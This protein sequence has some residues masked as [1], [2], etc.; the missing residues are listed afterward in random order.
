MTTTSGK[1][2]RQTHDRIAIVMPTWVGDSCMATPT[3]RALRQTY[4]SAEITMISRPV[5][6]ELIAGG[7]GE[8]A[9]WVDDFI[10]V[11]KRGHDD[12][13]SRL[14]LTKVC[15]ARKFDLAVLLTNSFWSAAVMRMAGV[16][17]IVGYNRDARS[18]LLTD[19]L[20]V[21][22]EAGKRKPISAVDYYLTLAQYLDADD[23]S[24]IEPSPTME[25]H[26][27]PAEATLASQLWTAIGLS[28]SHPTLVINSNAATDPRRLWPEER[29]AELAKRTA[30]ELDWQ[31][32]LHCGPTERESSARIAAEVADRRV[33]SMGVWKDLPIGLS[34]AVMQQADLV[35]STDSGPRHIA[36]ALNRQVIA[37]L[38]PIDPAWTQT[39]NQPEI[40]LRGS[41]TNK[42]PVMADISVDEVFEAIRSAVSVRHQFQDRSAA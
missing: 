11:S 20:S 6:K 22:M 36:V 31:V 42:E 5:I 26:V 3:L 12:S 32:L 29:V 27:S 34:K 21:P 37:L 35:V 2:Q 23:S 38:G 13:H 8:H 9:P 14:G 24:P 39:Y 15:R 30:T 40:L 10:Q 4:P 19:R 17:R 41:S 18:W 25:L 33:A 7:G 1:T 16:K 28:T